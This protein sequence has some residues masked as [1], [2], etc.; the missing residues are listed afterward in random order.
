MATGNQNQNRNEREEGVGEGVRCWAGLSFCATYYQLWTEADTG[1][2]TQ[3][4][5]ET[6]EFIG[7]L[8][9]ADSVCSFPSL[10]VQINF[11]L[12]AEQITTKYFA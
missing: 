8:T 7:T 2:R 9:A 11:L 12:S 10:F 5:P 1:T 3:H 4:T 6:V